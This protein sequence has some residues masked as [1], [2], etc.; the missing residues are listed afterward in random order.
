MKRLRIRG[1]K[2][3]DKNYLNLMQEISAAGSALI[4]RASPVFI[5]C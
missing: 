2:R 1:D 5:E 3:L 4:N